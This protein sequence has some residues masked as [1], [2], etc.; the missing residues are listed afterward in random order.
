[1]PA[2][3]QPQWPDA[4]A[5]AE[6]AAHLGRTPS[7]VLPQEC[8]TL[9]DRLAAVARGEAVILQGGDCAETFDGAGEQQVDAK[10]RTLNQMAAVIAEAA[11]APVVTIGRM[12]GQY[13]KPRSGTH[14]TRDGVTLPAY[15]G[16]LV[17]GSVFTAGS[18]TPQPDRLARAHRVSATTLNLLRALAARSRTEFWTS[19]EALVL[20][21][22][23][24]LTRGTPAGPYNLSAHTVWVGE[25]TRQLG[26]AHIDYVARIRNP[27]AVKVGPTTTPDDALALV[28]RLDPDREPGRLTFVAR[29]GADAVRD[30]LPDLVTK[31]SAAGS[32]V[33]WVCDPMHGNTFVAD[34]GFKTRRL[35]VIVDELRGFFEV[36]RALGT[37][38]GGVHTELTG[39]HVTECLGG[40]YPVT[41]TDLPTRYE[42]ACD[43]RLNRSQSLDLAWELADLYAEYQLSRR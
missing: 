41:P 5:L 21:Y 8:D 37:H 28:D 6:A 29:M 38:P 36:H 23:R 31:V 43:P 39:E 20:E 17:N 32:P 16:D 24:A 4:E 9:R 40:T 1:M 18:R 22:E 19:H 27:I 10:F 3:Q 2:A 25:R 11:V 7:L 42:T 26:G 13:A 34:G 33:I 30:V 35:D 12:A 15:R 14:E